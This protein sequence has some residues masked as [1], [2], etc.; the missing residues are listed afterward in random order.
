MCSTPHSLTR[1]LQNGDLGVS[2][3][4]ELRLV[5]ADYFLSHKRLQLQPIAMSDNAN[6]PSAQAPKSSNV[7]EMKDKTARQPGPPSDTG[8][9]RTRQRRV[10]PPPPPADVAGVPHRRPVQR[11]GARAAAVPYPPR[12]CVDTDGYA[13]MPPPARQ[14][15]PLRTHAQEP[16]VRQL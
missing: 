16:A 14:L 1:A 8:V 5:H 6:M 12:S 13:M 2:G 10:T 9:R 15:Y 7:A 11:C 3:L 4:R